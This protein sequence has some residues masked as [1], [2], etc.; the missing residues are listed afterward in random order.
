MDNWQL[1]NELAYSNPNKYQ[2]ILIE[3]LSANPI[4]KSIL[5]V[6]ERT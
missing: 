3:K 6:M 2:E 4:Y 5:E 1:T